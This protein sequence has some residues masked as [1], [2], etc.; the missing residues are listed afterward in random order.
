[1]RVAPEALT[2]LPYVCCN[3]QIDL[4]EPASTL[5]ANDWLAPELYYETGYEA[6][7]VLLALEDAFEAISLLLPA[8]VD[9]STR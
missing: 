6:S 9:H 5:D 7:E 3:A 1:M 2:R 4:S 8:R